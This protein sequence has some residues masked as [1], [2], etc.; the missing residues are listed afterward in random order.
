[1][2]ERKRF[3]G[4]SSNG[5]LQEALEK[6]AQE[7]LD[8]ASRQAADVRIKYMLESVSGE[9]GGFAGLRP[10]VTVVIDAEIP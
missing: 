4:V 2:S 6:A 10:Q 9:L 1:M 3:S 7:A 5:E 8:F